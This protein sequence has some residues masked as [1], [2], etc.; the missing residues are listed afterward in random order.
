MDNY[1]S[2]DVAAKLSHLESCYSRVTSEGALA[3]M[4][5]LTC[6]CCLRAYT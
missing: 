5:G 6:R 3:E 4:L 1:A 2:P